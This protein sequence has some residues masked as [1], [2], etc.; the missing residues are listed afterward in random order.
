MER[1]PERLRKEVISGPLQSTE[2][3]QHWPCVVGCGGLWGH[4]LRRTGMEQGQWCCRPAG[5]LQSETGVLLAKRPLASIQSSPLAM[6]PQPIRS[7]LSDETHL[8]THNE[9]AAFYSQY[10]EVSLINS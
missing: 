8:L 5:C 7:L 4:L 6:I 10:E 9:S 2:H 1:G 3:F